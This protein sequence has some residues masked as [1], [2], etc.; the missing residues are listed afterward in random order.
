[1]FCKKKF[2]KISQILQENT[3]VGVSIKKRLQHRCFPVKFAKFLRT[4]ILR[5]ICQRLLPRFSGRNINFSTLWYDFYDMIKS[6]NIF[7]R[8]FRLDSNSVSTSRCSMVDGKTILRGGSF[9]TSLKNDLLCDNSTFAFWSA[10]ISI[11]SRSNIPLSCGHHKCMV[12]KH[13]EYR[14]RLDY[15]KSP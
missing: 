2:L 3:C 6:W 5:N 9:I 1:M 4:P 12:Y 7:K 15:I 10:K 11:R 14:C 8:E 13:K